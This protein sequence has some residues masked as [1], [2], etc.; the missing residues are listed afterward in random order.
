MQEQDTWIYELAA[1]DSE[2]AGPCMPPLKSCTPNPVLPQALGQASPSKMVFLLRVSV[3][4]GSN[5][6][7][8]ELKTA[9]QMYSKS[10]EKKQHRIPWPFHAGK[11]FFLQNAFKLGLQNW[12]MG[13]FVKTGRYARG[14]LSGKAA[15]PLA[16]LQVFHF[17]LPKWEKKKS[18]FS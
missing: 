4:S 9:F 15:F 12:K 13:S 11:D 14:C 5:A 17:D 6:K 18:S 2:K 16:I 10:L 8:S 3:N 1:K 7:F